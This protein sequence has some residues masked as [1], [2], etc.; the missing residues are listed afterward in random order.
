MAYPRAVTW[1]PRPPRTLAL[2]IL[3]LAI[4]TGT[5][6]CA[7]SGR[8]PIPP[9]TS[10]PDRFL[11]ERGN[12]AL[13]NRRWLTAREYFKQVTEIYT[14]SPFRPE[15]KLGVGDSYLGEGSA[16]ALVLAINEFQEFLAFFPTHQ[17][18]DYAQFRLGMAHHRQMRAPQRD[19]T[20]TRAT[21]AEFSTFL[22]RYPNSSLRPEVE[23]RLREARDRLSTAEYEVG[24]HYFR[25]EW[26]PGAV[27]RFTAILTDDPAFTRRDAVYYYLGETLIKSGRSEDALP[28]FQKLL[29]EYQTSDHLESARRR[30]DE[31]K[32]TA[33]G[34]ATH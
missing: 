13:A 25:I 28:Y 9:G 17:R 15:A 32:T 4:L 3:A 29:E 23:E 11:F 2:G 31:L 8:G 34:Q 16:E 20:E 6:A 26:Y 21:V 10:E 18:A 22:V 33:A 14:Q 24:L 7:A 30:V 5:M 12:E 27:A 1:M 19:Q